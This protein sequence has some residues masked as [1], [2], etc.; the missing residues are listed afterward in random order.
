[1]TIQSLIYSKKKWSFIDAEVDIISKK[2]YYQHMIEDFKFYY[3]IV[4][5]KDPKKCYNRLKNINKSGVV[6]VIEYERMYYC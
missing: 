4:F 2:I 5:N 6:I 3:F 1:M